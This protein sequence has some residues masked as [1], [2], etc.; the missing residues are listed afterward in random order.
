MLNKK[1]LKLED[2][3]NSYYD[4]LIAE[5]NL[6]YKLIII[7][8]CDGVLTDG[9]Q[10]YNSNK[11]IIKK[12]GSS[13]TEVIKFLAE[14]T[15]TKFIF[16]TDDK[17]GFNITKARMKHLKNKIQNIDFILANSNERAEKVKLC[18]E[19]DNKVI[20]VGDSISDIKAMSNADLACCPS[21]SSK[22][23]K[24]YCDF[25]SDNDGG[26]RA[27]EQILIFSFFYFCTK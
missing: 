21:G 5:N 14:K 25:I 10:Y 23:V 11:K 3:Y 22:L 7:V 24:A 4:K 19:K 17:A 12:F 15:D 9:G 6:L 13:D 20:F 16:V 8:D 27:L 2:K 18:K 1:K 26:H